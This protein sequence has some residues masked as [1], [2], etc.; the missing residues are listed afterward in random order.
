MMTISFIILLGLSISSFSLYVAH[1]TK[2]SS[3]I[4]ISLSK[5]SI[6]ANDVASTKTDS[7]YNIHNNNNDSKSS[8]RDASINTDVSIEVNDD[9]RSGNKTMLINSETFLPLL[10]SSR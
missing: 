9:F 5:R 1:S 6:A 7:N 10:Q 3:L 2:A 4:T 8:K